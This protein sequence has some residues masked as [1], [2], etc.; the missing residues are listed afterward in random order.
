MREHT[1][2]RS[3][4][5]RYFDP[6]T[7][8]RGDDY[9]SDSRVI[10]LNVD[11]HGDDYVDFSSEVKGSGR[12][13]YSQQVT[14]D[15]YGNH[16]G[17]DG[18][19]DCPMRH[20]CKHVVAACLHFHARE[21]K[22]V[23]A[24][25][26][27]LDWI[28]RFAK[29]SAPE[30]VSGGDSSDFLAYVLRPTANDK[31]TV[32]VEFVVTKELKKGG[33][34]KGRKTRLDSLRQLHPLNSYLHQ[35]DEDI[36]A[37]LQVI[38]A[39]GWGYTALRGELGYICA[40]KILSTGRGFWLGLQRPLQFID[41]QRVL[42]AHWQQDEKSMSTLHLE[43]DPE[44]TILL[45]D[46]PLYLDVE[47][48]VVGPL[49]SGGYS[50]AQ[51]QQ[52]LLAPAIPAE[53]TQEFSQQLVLAVPQS[54]LSPPGQIN[55]RDINVSPVPHV[56]LSS[57]N[58]SATAQRHNIALQFDYGGQ[59]LPPGTEQL[60]VSRHLEDQVVRIHR[61]LEAEADAITQLQRAGFCAIDTIATT[62]MI[63][64]SNEQLSPLQQITL[65]DEFVKVVVPRLQLQGW[66]VEIDSSFDLVVHRGDDWHVDI[67]EEAGSS[68]WFELRFDIMVDGRSIPLFPLVTQ[69]LEHYEPE[70]MP[71]LLT[72][73]LQ[74][75]EYVTVSRARLKPVLDTLY[76]LHNR[77]GAAA[78][79]ALKLSHFDSARL[80]E[81]EVIDNVQ[82][83]G[84][85]GLR[86]LG[87]KLQDFSGIEQVNCPL[88]LNASLRDYQQEG[89][90]WLQFLREYNFGGILADDMGLGKTVQALAHLLVEK[91]QGRMDKPC[92]IV[93]PTSVLSNWRREAQ[94]FAPS[95]K[96][97]LLQGADRRQHFV[98]IEQHD[99][100]LTSYPLLSR[101]QEALTDRDYHMLILDE[102]QVVKNPKVKAA[103]VIRKIQ[104]RHR[105]CLTGTPMENHLGEL[106]A[107]F[108]FL[109]PGFLGGSRQFTQLYRSPIEKHGDDERRRAL[110]ARVAPFLLRR[111]KTQVAAELPEKSQ[112][113]HTVSLQ[114]KQAALYESIRIA[115]E[116]K[117][118][119]AIAAKGLAGSHITILDA[120]LKLRQACCDP[121][122]LPLTQAKSVDESAKMEWLM[123]V[124]P[125]MVEEGR[126]ILLFSQFTKMLSLIEEQLK[127]QAI[128]YSKLTGQ[129]RN[130]DAAIESFKS[131]GAAVFLISLKAGGVGLNL[132]EADT[133][134]HYDPWWNPAAENQ[135]TDRAHR[136]G[137]KK[138]V[139]V[140]KLITEN[141]VE[142]KIVAMQANKQALVQ[143]VYQDGEQGRGSQLN[144]D[145]LKQLFAPLS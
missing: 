27:V 38:N 76:E 19:C 68:D 126:R 22:P 30:P 101:D 141:S 47:E 80:N 124:L 105:L 51:L 66:F 130:R 34:S 94:Q 81:L 135:A 17:I 67:D 95:L 57:Q 50:Y 119:Q 121:R 63:F 42:R 7:F 143:G 137:Q 140:Y 11:D 138:S 108:D 145:D 65:F 123:Q 37:L 44:A 58:T 114:P 139:F 129:T 54:P 61:D 96:V 32:T 132:T 18:N 4:L 3:Q 46:P 60:L 21:Q 84:G 40:M 136:I 6:K 90:N 91:E 29:A 14:V 23:T 25:H 93:A 113:I 75:S 87:R 45:L 98:Q 127:V 55:S 31:A 1:E 10:S 53:L 5:L 74:G 117:V 110:V 20:N 100:I 125:E 49:D 144:G 24:Q 103:A 52:L 128:S 13:V 99:L 109:M 12:N 41:Q 116:K 111:S 134:I 39:D 8:S 89:L 43:I 115:M 71:E 73:H 112:I 92:L 102:A 133:V 122:L 9:F 70:Q 88:G 106:W 97:L 56:V 78:P 36:L 77:E 118:Q 85:D 120:L 107:L 82:W 86:E 131:G 83:R 69:V 33:L 72:L 104:C 79:A 15:F 35:Q 2:L 16:I 62:E 26:N 64:Y 142:E 28:E 48:A 59:L